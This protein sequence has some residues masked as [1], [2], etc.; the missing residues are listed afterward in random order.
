[1][2]IKS[3]H[4]YRS[5]G[6]GGLPTDLRTDNV[7]YRKKKK[8]SEESERF[9]WCKIYNIECI[10]SHIRVRGQ[11]AKDPLRTDLQTYGQT[12]RQHDS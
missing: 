10:L 8:Q 2:Y 12:D 7:T 4:S 3:H 11:K 5:K 9:L 6:V 1:M